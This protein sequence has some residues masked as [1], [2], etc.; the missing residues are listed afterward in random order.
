M[1][2]TSRVLADAC[3]RGPAQV[4]CEAAGQGSSAILGSV[5]TTWTPETRLYSDGVVRA[6]AGGPLVVPSHSGYQRLPG[7]CFLDPGHGWLDGAHVATPAEVAEANRRL[8]HTDLPGRNG[9]FA[10]MAVTALLDMEAVCLPNGAAVAA[11]SP[12]WSYVW[13]RDA[14]YLAAAFSILGRHGQAQHLLQYVASMQEPDGTWQARY[15]PD[16]SGGVPDDR[17]RQ[18]D[19]SG[20]FLWATWVGAQLAA[21]SRPVVP[22]QLSGAASFA[23]RAVIDMI[24]SSTGLPPPSQDYWEVDV[25][26]VTLG[27]AAPLLLALRTGGDIARWRG[28][29]SLADAARTTA[30]R[31]E[32]AIRDTFSGGGYPRIS[33]RVDG[34]DASIAF[35]MPPFAP[36]DAKVERAW[37]KTFARLRVDNGGLRPGQEWSDTQTAWTPQTA[38]FALT[39]ACSGDSSMATDLLRWLA[40]RTTRW[41]SLPEKVTAD[42]HPAAVA[43]LPL[44]SATVLLALATLEGRGLP[45][46]TSEACSIDSDHP[47]RTDEGTTT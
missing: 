33:G 18:L 28:E 39:A 19:N 11:A 20:W 46:P 32:A 42:G 37:R 21:P 41:G 24:D 30:Y 15:L 13:P 10:G 44:T 36:A 17:G 9:Q 12:H 29:V 5:G 1:V 23:L 22:E 26:E 14:S 40:E 31:L 16:G 3:P 38:L 27:V 7:T 34:G 4:T 2:R 47:I 43:P 6:T 35:L 25:E 8:A 45:V